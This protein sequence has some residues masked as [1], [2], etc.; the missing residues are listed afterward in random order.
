M[1]S[2]FATGKITAEQHHVARGAYALRVDLE[3][4]VWPDPELGDDVRVLDDD[5]LLAVDPAGYLDI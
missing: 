2:A 4:E 1:Q 3:R 5:R